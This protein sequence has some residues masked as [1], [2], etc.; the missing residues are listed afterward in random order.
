MNKIIEMKFGSHLYGTTTPNSDTDY[1]AIYIPTAQQIADGHWQKTIVRSRGK[2]KG[3]RNTKDD[4]DIEI[5]SLDRFMELL[6]EGQTVALDMLFAPKNMYQPLS[7]GDHSSHIWQM[8]LDHKDKI[9]NKKV[10]SFIGYARKQAAKYGVKGSRMEALKQVLDLLNSKPDKYSRM[11]AYTDELSDLIEK[12]LEV[13]SLEKIPLIR[14]ESLHNPHQDVMVPHLQVCGKNYPMRERIKDVAQKLQYRYNEYGERAVKAHLNGGKDYKALSH[15][16]RV[17]SQGLELLRTGTITFPRP[18]AGLLLQ[19]KNGMLAWEPLSEMI[20]QGLKDLVEAE[21][22]STLRSEPDQEWIDN[23][24]Q[25]V[26]SNI[27]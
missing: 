12:N 19:V 3:E 21:K 7:N 14:F 23:F 26:Y 9:V 24:I 1:K 16:V 25:D 5:F 18:D 13:V 2:D 15:A 11:D 8:I 10:S 4:I 27:R 20:E 17:N 6:G 22:V